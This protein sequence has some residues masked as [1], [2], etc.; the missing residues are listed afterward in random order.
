MLCTKIWYNNMDVWLFLLVST[1]PLPKIDIMALL[2]FTDYTVQ[3]YRIGYV[4]IRIGIDCINYKSNIIG[5]LRVTALELVCYTVK[6]Q[7][8]WFALY[9]VQCVLCMAKISATRFN[10]WER[11]DNIP[12]GFEWFLSHSVFLSAKP[13]SLSLSHSLSSNAFEMTEN[14]TSTSVRNRHIHI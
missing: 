5:Y 4:S 14:S 10:R 12:K 7:P 6:A 2:I 3:Q 1:T 9:T 8:Y 11:V 13:L